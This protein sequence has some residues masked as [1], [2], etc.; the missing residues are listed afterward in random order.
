MV[1]GSA[2]GARVH[3]GFS[4]WRVEMT[5]RKETGTAESEARWRGADCGGRMSL[6]DV[7]LVHESFLTTK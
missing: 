1:K 2:E 7:S 4:L 6:K 5:Y 3:A